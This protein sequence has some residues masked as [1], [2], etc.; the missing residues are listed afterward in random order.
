MS[1]PY[2]LG[3]VP[4]ERRLEQDSDGLPDGVTFSVSRFPHATKARIAAARKNVREVLDE[5]LDRTTDPWTDRETGEAYEMV[6]GFFN[7][8]APAESGAVAFT[9]SDGNIIGLRPAG[10]DGDTTSTFIGNLGGGRAT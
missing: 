3:N 7:I 10:Y 2:A 1:D 4:T 6:R 8:V 5:N 9:V